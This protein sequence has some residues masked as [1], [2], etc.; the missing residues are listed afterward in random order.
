MLAARKP[1]LP[2]TNSIWF[3]AISFH[4]YV[5]GP[6]KGLRGQGGRNSYALSMADDDIRYYI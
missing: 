1:I 5:K 3:S 6:S 4:V 2:N